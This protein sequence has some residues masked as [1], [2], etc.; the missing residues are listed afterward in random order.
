VPLI[1]HPCAVAAKA[2]D[3]TGH[4]FTVKV[5]GGL[6]GVPFSRHGKRDLI[7][8]LTGQQDVPVLVLDDGTPIHG[9]ASIVSWARENPA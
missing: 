3:E 8:E 5:V 1:K 7:V 6:K 2:L 4:T 9:T